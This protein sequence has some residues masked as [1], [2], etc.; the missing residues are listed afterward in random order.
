[1][2]RE[3][4]KQNV[5]K[6]NNDVLVN[7]G[8][9]YTTNASYSAVVANQQMTKAAVTRIP[10]GVQ[11][12]IDFGCGDGTYTVEL[13]RSFPNIEIVGVD[14][15]IDAI[16]RARN[17]TP[18][19]TFRVANLLEPA[20]LPQRV[21]D[22]GI[23]RGVI[24]HLPDGPLGI[25]NA[26]RICKTLIVIE[27]NG[28]NPIVK[29][30]EKHSQYHIEHEEQSFT[31]QELLSWCQSAGC[32]HVRVDYIGFVPMFFPAFWVSII[33]FLE[34]LFE[35]IYPLKKYFSAQIVLTCAKDS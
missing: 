8:Y 29:W 22:V 10:K 21:F 12:L 26:A 11:S 18:L 33:R 19:V 24:H 2:N 15:A 17:L 25:K 13:A 4:I 20:T 14:P 28:N 9:Q 31:T 6:F 32:K 30:I 3:T 1:M 7:G 16:T 23:I 34:P 5:G 27:P 35:C